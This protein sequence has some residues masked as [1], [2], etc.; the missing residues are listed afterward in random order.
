MSFLIGSDIF[1]RN[2]AKWLSL[3]LALILFYA[4]LFQ[5]SN[6]SLILGWKIADIIPLGFIIAVIYAYF[7]YLYN[8]RGLL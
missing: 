2:M 6:Y 5:D 8:N 4:T 7:F 3:F 1:R